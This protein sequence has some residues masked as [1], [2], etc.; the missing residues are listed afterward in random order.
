GDGDDVAGDV[1]AGWGCGDRGRRWQVVE[2]KWRR[3]VVG[4]G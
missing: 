1:A 3:V 2:R 4:I